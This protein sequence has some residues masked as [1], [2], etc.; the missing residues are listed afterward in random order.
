MKRVLI[1]FLLVLPFFATAQQVKDHV[2]HLSSDSLK[3]YFVF[4][5]D[6]KFHGGDGDSTL[7]LPDYNDNNWAITNPSLWIIDTRKDGLDTF[8]S[9]CW[10]RL[11]LDIDTT[12]VGKQIGI[13]MSHYGASEVYLDGKKIKTW[14]KIKGKDSSDYYDPQYTPFVIS[15]NTPGP[16]VIAVRYANYDAQRNKSVYGRDFAGF[17]MRAGD[18]SRIIENRNDQILLNTFIFI[19]LF[20]IFITFSFIH[21]FLFLYYRAARSNLFFSIFCFSLAILFFTSFLNQTSNTPS[22]ELRANLILLIFTAVICASLSGFIN[23]LFSNTKKLRAHI[24][25]VICV[26]APFL[27]YIDINVGLVAYVV[28]IVIVSLEAIILTIHAIYKKVPGSRIV[29]FGILFLTLFTL[30]IVILAILGEA[31]FDDSTIGGKLFELLLAGAILSV[32]VSM[33]IYLAWSFAKVNKDLK[34]QLEQIKTLSEEALEH[35]LEK[36]RLLESQNEKLEKEVA[37]R[38]SEIAQQHEELKAEKKKSDDLLNNILPEEVAEELKQKGISSARFF[39]HV[40]VLFTDFVAF[41]K[42]GERMSPQ[43][44]VDELHTC[45]K[46]FDDIISK[47]NIEKIK[48]IGD[49]YLAVCG[50]PASDV[51]HALNVANAAIEIKQYMIARK[52]QLGDKTFEIRIGIHSGSVVAGIVGVKKFAYD[53]WG[54]TVNTAA[55]MEQN[56]EPGKINISQTTYELVKDNFD[57]TYRGEITAKNKGELS[58]YFITGV[59]A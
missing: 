3:G 14:G 55:R 51:N 41:T 42:A 22:T 38:T 31:S 8:N 26:L 45:F 58:M 59:K 57:C 44:L 13:Q 28:L 46:A 49:A 6:W 15:F 5:T 39:D 16:H 52:Q 35:E 21:L 24:V 12:I 37:L 27:F 47:Y 43:E 40:T 48:T 1:L 53:I 11:H 34:T 9:I 18:A 54:D 36:K 19:L 30:T 7:A 20:G 4:N 32:P 17:R 56:S 33:S 23:D 2:I 10:M 25:K 29:G 50:L